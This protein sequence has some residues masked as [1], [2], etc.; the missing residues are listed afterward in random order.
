M[1]LPKLKKE[2]KEAVFSYDAPAGVVPVAAEKQ[3]MSK[4]PEV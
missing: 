1:D 3:I 4:T 2:E